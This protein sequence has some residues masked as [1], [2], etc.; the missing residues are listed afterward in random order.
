M[1]GR[2]S[3]F[4]MVVALALAVAACTPSGAPTPLPTKEKTIGRVQEQLQKAD[5]DVAKRREAIDAVG[6]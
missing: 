1:S 4:G 3:V 5:D 2:R 6:K